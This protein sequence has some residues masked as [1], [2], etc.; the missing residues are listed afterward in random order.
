MLPALILLVESHRGEILNL[1]LRK[2]V[3]LTLAASRGVTD[4]Y[5]SWGLNIEHARTTF[6]KKLVKMRFSSQTPYYKWNTWY[7]ISTPKERV[8]CIPHIA[9]LSFNHS[10]GRT[11][12]WRFSFFLSN[13]LIRQKEKKINCACLWVGA[14]RRE[15]TRKKGLKS[16]CHKDERHDLYWGEGGRAFYATPDLSYNYKIGVREQKGEDNKRDGKTL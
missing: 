9:K 14:N 5:P 7:R 4:L 3:L 1:L 13:L 2:I 8:W 15:S 10:I 12:S 11:L 6:R 16:S